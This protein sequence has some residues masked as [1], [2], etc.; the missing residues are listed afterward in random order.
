VYIQGKSVRTSYGNYEEQLARLL[1]QLD[2]RPQREYT[3]RLV[4]TLV[5]RSL[6]QGHLCLLQTRK[7]SERL[8]EQSEWRMRLS[9]WMERKLGASTEWM[10]RMNANE[11]KHLQLITLRNCLNQLK[12]QDRRVQINARIAYEVRQRMRLWRKQAE[13]PKRWTAE[14]E[15]EKV[16]IKTDTDHE[17]GLESEKSTTSSV[18]ADKRSTQGELWTNANRATGAKDGGAK[19]IRSPNKNWQRMEAKHRRNEEYQDEQ[20]EQDVEALSGGQL[21]VNGAWTDGSKEARKKAKRAWNRRMKERFNVRFVIRPFQWVAKALYEAFVDTYSGGALQ[22]QVGNAGQQ[23]DAPPP[24]NAP[25]SE[26]GA[27][28]VTAALKQ[29]NWGH[30]RGPFLYARIE[31]L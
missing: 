31:E 20:D 27:R 18:G 10:N 2:R 19:Q 6:R 30:T 24:P 29:L 3:E 12:V 4:D 11:M 5:M 26:M 17:N 14:E 8:G 28:S 7:K 9:V 1:A 16:S 23:M 13:L 22:V 21:N 15:A 25:F